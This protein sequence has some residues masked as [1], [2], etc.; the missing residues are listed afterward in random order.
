MIRSLVVI[1]ALL[2][3]TGVGV[4][5]ANEGAVPVQAAGSTSAPLLTLIG[6]TRDLDQVAVEGAWHLGRGRVSV[7]AGLG[8]LPRDDEDPRLRLAGIRLFEGGVRLHT[9]WFRRRG[10]VELG[11]GPLART[12]RLVPNEDPKQSLLYGPSLLLGYQ[13][14]AKS[15][16]TFLAAAGYCYKWS[17][18]NGGAV[19]NPD[20]RIGLGY[21][22][23]AR[24]RASPGSASTR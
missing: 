23:R 4:C 13:H 7:F 21:T 24:T 19:H 15:H 17:S 2:S 8:Y 9:G 5:A 16:L 6:E 22:W 3:S 18:E 10:Y 20:F 1:L 14:I 12:V 11:W